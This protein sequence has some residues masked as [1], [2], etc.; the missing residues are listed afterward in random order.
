MSGTTVLWRCNLDEAIV[1][2][3]SGANQYYV[4]RGGNW[5]L[6][7]V[8]EGGLFQLPYLRTVPDLTGAN[9]LLSLPQLPSGTVGGLRGL[10]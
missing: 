8:I 9:N 6:V 4:N 7:E 10:F 3:K 5:V 1:R 2:S